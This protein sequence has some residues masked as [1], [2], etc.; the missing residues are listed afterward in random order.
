[1]IE[2]LEKRIDDRRFISL[3]TGMLRAGY[4]EDWTY[5]PTYSGT[6]QGGIVSPILSNIY[7][8]LFGRLGTVSSLTS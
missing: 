3:I 7:G 6:P 8:R 2:L 1:M 5:Y 4:L